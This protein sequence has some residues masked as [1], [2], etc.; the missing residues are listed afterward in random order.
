MKRAPRGYDAGEPV[1]LNESATRDKEG[2]PREG[3]CEEEIRN[4]KTKP[5]PRRRGTDES[6]DKTRKIDNDELLVNLAKP[7]NL[8]IMVRHDGGKEEGVYIY[9][10]SI[11]EQHRA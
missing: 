8:L 9:S 10:P 7:I 2:R 5:A 4:W 6:W 3:R 1:G 11:L